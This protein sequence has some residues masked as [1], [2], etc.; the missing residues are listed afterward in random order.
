MYIFLYDNMSMHLKQAKG[1]I[2]LQTGQLLLVT[3]L[4]L[5]VATT[6][7]LSLIGRATLDLSM[8]NQLEESTRAFNA[9]EAGIESALLSG[10]SAYDVLVASGVTY[11]VNVNDIGGASGVFQLTHKTNRG[12]VESLWLVEH[13]DDTGEIIETP[14]YTL[15]TIDVCWTRTNTPAVV[16]GVV[17]KEGTDGTYKIARAAVDANSAIRSNNFAI[18]TAANNGCGLSEYYG[19]TLNFGTLGISTSGAG[20]DT[21]IALRI[22]PEYADATLAVNGGVVGVP[23]QGNQIESVGTTASGLS[24][25]VIVYQQYRTAPSIFDYVIYSQSSFG[26]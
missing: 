5:T 1:K 4:I 7:A 26:H 22:R 21:L 8:S 25:K 15:P 23:K 10:T 2:A 17:Y 14:Y 20:A 11:S 12:S 24:R 13:D 16:I 3:I 18:P 6:I 9:A 19:Y